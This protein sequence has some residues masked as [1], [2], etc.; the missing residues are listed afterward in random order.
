MRLDLHVVL[1]PLVLLTLTAARA[2]D[3]KPPAPPATFDL[4]AI[5]AYVAAEVRDQGYPGLALAIARDG[6]IVLAKGYGRCSLPNG[7]SVRPETPFAIGS[8]TKQF[9]CACI[10]LLAEE[11]K[12]ALDDP[13]AK[14]YPNL[15]RARDITLYDLM[16]HASGYPDY[17]PLDFVDRRLRSPIVIDTL[18]ARYAGGALDFEPGTRWSYSNTGYLLLGR[19]VEKVAGEPFGAFLTRRILKPV[20]MTHSAFE[21]GE[22]T[23]GLATGHTAF[24]LGPPEPAPR[25]A[26]GWLH[27]AGGLWASAPDLARWDLAL[28]EGHVL[29]PDSFRRM[30]EPRRLIGGRT[31]DYGCGLGIARVSGEMALT[32]GGAVSGFLAFNAI[33]PRTRSAIVVLTNGE[34]VRLNALQS[35]LLALLMKAQADDGGSGVPKVAGPK[36]EEA[37][38]DVFRQMQAGSLDR[39]KLGEEFSIYLDEDRV[40]EAAPRLEALGEPESVVVTNLAE[41]GGMEVA[42]LR[43]RFKTATLEVSMMRSPDGKIQQLLL[44][45]G[46]SPGGR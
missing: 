19:V 17:Y 36:P 21:P 7:D 22:A 41:R 43:F 39:S 34:H 29:E 27:A 33:V 24:V 4:E 35:T 45:R 28:I 16:T 13:V 26:D 15:T 2:G 25:E 32:H 8:V 20:G 11:G 37:A 46:P 44:R 14:F 12:L 5:D 30:T 31:H 1:F 3:A 6:K 10:L 42:A 23:K 9:T 38:L 40:R 18:L